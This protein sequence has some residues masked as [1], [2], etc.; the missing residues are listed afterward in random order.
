MA[1]NLIT[2]ITGAN[3]GIGYYAAGHFAK[4]GKYKVLLGCRDVNK[5]AKAIE[6]LVA[7]EGAVEDAFDVVQLDVTSDESI[8]KAAKS[9]EEEYGRLDIVRL[10][11]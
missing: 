3:Q 11:R 6:Q 5:A 7:E 2:L 1:E 10:P 4:A 8:E 9:I